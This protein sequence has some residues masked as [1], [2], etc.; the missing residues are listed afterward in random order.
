MTSMLEPSG[1]QPAVGRCASAPN[2]SALFL[3][4]GHQEWGLSAHKGTIWEIH[5]CLTVISHPA[6][7]AY[8]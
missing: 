3:G 1:E 8:E 5:S 2:P 6:Y 7:C 4:T